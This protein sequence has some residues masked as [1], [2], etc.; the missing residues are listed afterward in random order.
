MKTSRRALVS[1]CAALSLSLIIAA[2]LLLTGRLR[3]YNPFLIR[4]CQTELESAALLAGAFLD[5]PGS[6]AEAVLG[7]RLGAAPE[8]IFL[9]EDPPGLLLGCP[10]SLRT[11]AG[12]EAAAFWRGRGFAG[13]LRPPPGF[14]AFLPV[15]ELGGLSRI[16]FY[17]KNRG[18]VGRFEP[19]EAFEIPAFTGFA[20]FPAF[21]ICLWLAVF[22]L[23]GPVWDP[24][25]LIRRRAMLLQAQL[26]RK[27]SGEEGR[28]RAGR[29]HLERRREDLRREFRRG[30][31]RGA[32]LWGAAWRDT[33]LRDGWRGEAEV[34]RRIEQALDD[35]LEAAR[36]GAPAEMSPAPELEFFESPEEGSPFQAPPDLEED[37]GQ[38]GPEPVFSNKSG[39]GFPETEIWGNSQEKLEFID[40]DVLGYGTG[41]SSGGAVKTKVEAHVSDVR[42]E[43][44]TGGTEAPQEL[45]E[46]LEE[47][48]ELEELEALEE[49][50]GPATAVAS[51]ARP[52]FG[53]LASE[54]EFAPVV[55]IDESEP[56][57]A[58]DMA[59]LEIVDPFAEMLSDLSGPDGDPEF[60]KKTNHPGP[61]NAS[62]SGAPGTGAAE[63]YSKGAVFPAAGSF[64][65]YYPGGTVA[66]LGPDPAAPE[67]GVIL[68]QNGLHSINTRYFTPDRATLDSLDGE[69]R[70]LV[71]SVLRSGAPA[72]HL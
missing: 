14:A 15:F 40:E 69:F 34:N 4:Q 2:L 10:P 49:E 11:E 72:R 70:K 56:L 50:D 23:F 51:G 39:A 54:I 21:F 19:E 37:S 45:I 66:A 18:F 1:F 53:A 43:G 29:L 8:E 27:L 17:T 33:A 36:D 32:A 20:F 35:I 42:K 41:L 7:E 63:F 28:F 5:A 3:F 65:A 64:Y 26:H 9:I 22:L 38:S 68:E 31:G 25:K 47:L 67:D 16:L 71:T 59:G 48:E 46:D 57:M 55:E 44:G 62:L 61:L 30:I 6:G 24:L 58:A 13:A 12:A 60:K 52:D